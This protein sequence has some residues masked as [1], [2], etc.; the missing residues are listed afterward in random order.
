MAKQ[1]KTNNFSDAIIDSWNDFKIYDLKINEYS[2]KPQLLFK[3]RF[4]SYSGSGTIDYDENKQIRN[5]FGDNDS[6]LSLDMKCREK[7]PSLKPTDSLYN[8]SGLDKVFQN[9][10]DIFFK[11]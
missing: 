9:V 1:F 4:K 2:L 6:Y 11:K 8:D 7:H 10:L 5:V 3:W